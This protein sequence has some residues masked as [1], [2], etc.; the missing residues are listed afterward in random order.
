MKNYKMTY[1]AE[2]E[3]PDVDTNIEIPEHIGSY[4][5]EDFTIANSDGLANDP[6]KKY[7]VVGSEVNMK[8]TDSIDEMMD[9]IKSLYSLISTKTNHKSN[10][11]IHVGM[12][13]L[14][15]DFEKLHKLCKYTYANGIYLMN[16]VDPLPEPTTDKMAERIKHLKK[17]H[18]QT[19]PVNW[20]RNAIGATTWEGIRDAQQPVHKETGRRLTHLAKR[21]GINIRS[22][23][24]NGTIEFRHFFG[25]DDFDQ[26][27][28]AL[29]WCKLY[30]ENA[31]GDQKHPNKLLASREWNFPKMAPWNEELQTMWEYTNLEHNKRGEVKER[32]NQLL[33]ENKINRQHLGSMFG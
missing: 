32:I 25:T 16:K 9:N 15:E 30:V 7:F 6:K 10:L 29:E 23:W 11:H 8:P 26:Y 22:L 24:D 19:L 2:L 14:S 31:I 1:G 28:D 13:G 3:L 17:S 20:Q 21:C 18:Q 27:R 4:D 12:P 5:M 33:N